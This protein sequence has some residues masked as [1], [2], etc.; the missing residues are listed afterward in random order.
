MSVL[1]QHPMAVRRSTVARWFVVWRRP[2]MS[3]HGTPSA[4]LWYKDAIIYELHVRA[5]A[6]SNDD[7]IGDF[8]GLTAKLTTCRIWGSRRSGCCRSIRRR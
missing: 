6:D 4:S 1:S 3:L 2:G 5:F 7:G 8:C